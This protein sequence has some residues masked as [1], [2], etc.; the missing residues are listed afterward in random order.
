MRHA[1]LLLCVAAG[2]QSTEVAREGNAT[3]QVPAAVPVTIVQRTTEPVPGSIPELR[4]RI[5][6]ITAGAVLVHVMIGEDDVIS[7]RTMRVGDVVP[8][9]TAR[10]ERC[11]GL[12]QLSNVLIGDDWALFH[13]GERPAV[14]NAQVEHMIGRVEQADV[15]IVR[16][17]VAQHGADVARHLRAMRKGEAARDD[18]QQFL[19][20]LANAYE[21]YMVQRGGSGS[22]TPAAWLR[23]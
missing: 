16:H 23:S 21:P 2:C 13:V 10:G 8:F 15:G 9:P 6:D 7:Q 14:T 22:T 11:L 17:G 20:R 1:A 4:I 19:V 12:S 18:A 3:T 5:G